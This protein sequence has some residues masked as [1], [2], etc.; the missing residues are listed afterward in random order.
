MKG[1]EM[2]EKLTDRESKAPNSAYIEAFS[3]FLVAQGSPHNTRITYLNFVRHLA[4]FLGPRSFVV[5]RLFDLT[6]FQGF[7]YRKQYSPASLALAV[8]SLRK[9]Y[10]FLERGEAVSVS[11]ARFIHTPKQPK[12]LPACPS[13]DDVQ[14]LI[15]AATSP[16]DLALLEFL[17]ATGCRESEASKMNVEEVRLSVRTATVRR[18][19]GG[20]D[21]VVV[22]GRPAARAI[23]AYL[24]ERSSGLL[25]RAEHQV[26][27]GGVSRDEYGVWRGYWRERSEGGRLKME[28]VRLGDYEITS[29]EQ[30][31]LAL[32]AYLLQLRVAT[33][34]RRSRLSV[35]TIQRIVVATAMRAGLGHVNAHKLRHAFATHCV[36][37]GMDIRYAQELLGHESIKTT[38]KYLASSPAKLIEVHRKFFQ[39]VGA[40]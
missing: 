10:K 37:H 39:E 11:P 32:E 20:K 30:A 26:Q 31:Q 29:K 25:F 27:K 12:R 5:V 1:H 22:F 4:D 38:Q 16:R 9:F 23:R 13:E 21:R 14:R 34:D 28:S 40:R 15:A 33:A 35:R 36:D 24:G 17:Y 19:K 2:F 7:L 18:G 6:E 3:N 8:H